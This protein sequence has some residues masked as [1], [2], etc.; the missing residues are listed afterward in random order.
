[1]LTAYQLQENLPERDIWCS[2][3]GYAGRAFPYGTYSTFPKSCDTQ[4]NVAQ[5]RRLKSQFR[6]VGEELW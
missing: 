5:N 2:K 6:E 1:M 4:P 3:S